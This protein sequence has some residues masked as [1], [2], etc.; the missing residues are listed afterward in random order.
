VNDENENQ[1]S[2]PVYGISVAAE[3]LGIGVQTLRMYENRGL[4]DPAR[5]AGG[6]R[7]YS[8]KDLDRIDRVIVLLRDGLNL[9]GIAM[10]LDLQDENEQL[11]NERRGP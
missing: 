1:Y 9:A 4:V 2:Q 6:T 10:V 11:R 7:R 3:L 8:K 5:T